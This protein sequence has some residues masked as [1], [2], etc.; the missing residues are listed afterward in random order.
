MK[1]DIKEAKAKHTHDVGCQGKEEK[2]EVSVVPATNTVVHPR[3]VMI[4]FLYTVVTDTAVGASRRAVKAAGGAPFH[5]HLDTLDLHRFVKGS[6]EI[7]FF[8]FVFFS[9]G[10]N[11]WV[12]KGGHAEVGQ[13]KEEH[14]CI[15]NGHCR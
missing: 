13:H 9:S 12:H 2:E 8:V 7:I 15:V 10:E 11:S 6:S 5:S 14:N 3:A 4:K 1:E